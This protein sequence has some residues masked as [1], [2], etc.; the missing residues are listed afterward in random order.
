M[1]IFN[2]TLAV[3][4][5]VAFLFTKRSEAKVPSM[6][7]IQEP[8]VEAYVAGGALLLLAISSILTVFIV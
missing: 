4:A 8:P 1:V 6:L 3:I 5:L 2:A 7:S